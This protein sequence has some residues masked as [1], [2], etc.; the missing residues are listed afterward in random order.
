MYRNGNFMH[1]KNLSSINRIKFSKED[2]FKISYILQEIHSIKQG[3]KFVSKFYTEL[4]I[5]WEELEALRH[6]LDCIC[7]TKC[8][9]VLVKSVKHYAE[10]KQVICLLKG[11]GEVYGIVRTQI[12]MMEPLPSIGK[13]HNKKGNLGGNYILEFNFNII[14]DANT[15]KMIRLAELK[16]GLYHIKEPE[17]LILLHSLFFVF[18]LHPSNKVLDQQ[19]KLPFSSSLIVTSCAFELIHMDILGPLS[20]PLIQGHKYFLTVDMPEFY[21]QFGIN[22]QTYCIDTPWQNSIIERKHR[23]ILNVA[24]SILFHAC[25]PNICWSYA[26]TRAVHL[27]NSLEPK[28]IVGTRSIQS[29]KV[30]M[31]FILII[32]NLKSVSVSIHPMDI[33]I[34]STVP[35]AKI[36]NILFVLRIRYQAV[37]S[38]KWV[39]AMKVELKTFKTNNTWHIT[40]FQKYEG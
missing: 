1:H 37:S 29:F 39:H 5:L 6:I 40:E 17:E 27:F 7:A 8:N 2:Y 13:W 16:N 35:A 24:Q 32:D 14:F 4:K 21:G 31:I 15:L 30:L 18:L 22:H 26:V 38:M 33:S 34:V 3:E 20:I 23:H 12:L 10:S 28:V 36:E 19:T 25:L 9:C 11:L